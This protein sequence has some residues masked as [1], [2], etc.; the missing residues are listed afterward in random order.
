MRR[1]RALAFPLQAV[2][3]HPAIAPG[4]V[5]G[6]VHDPGFAVVRRGGERIV[7]GRSPILAASSSPRSSCRNCRAP[8]RRRCKS[9]STCHRGP[10]PPRPRPCASC[11][12]RRTSCAGQ[13][14]LS[15]GGQPS[16]CAVWVVAPD[17]NTSVTAGGIKSRPVGVVQYAKEGVLASQWLATRHSTQSSVSGCRTWMIAAPPAS[18]GTRYPCLVL[19]CV[20][21]RAVLRRKEN[22]QAEQAGLTILKAR[23][24]ALEQYAAAGRPYC[25]RL[26]RAAASPNRPMP[27]KAIEAGSGTAAGAMMSFVSRNACC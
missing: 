14:Q 6:V 25:L 21:G 13:E 15:R 23:S 24:P 27:S 3:A 8:R 1:E 19:K 26:R 5:P 20:S 16:R 11:T 12:P 7:P 2:D 18:D 22:G 10:A 4:D 17:M 9:S